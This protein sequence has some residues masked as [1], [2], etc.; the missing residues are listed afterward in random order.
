VIE[1]TVTQ[2]EGTPINATEPAPG[3]QSTGATFAPGVLQT[4]ANDEYPNVPYWGEA[5]VDD[6]S[7]HEFTYSSGTYEGQKVPCATLVATD[8]YGCSVTQISEA[9]PVSC[10]SCDESSDGWSVPYS[11]RSFTSS[12][13]SNEDQYWKSLDLLATAESNK[14]EMC[15]NILYCLQNPSVDTC[16]AL[17]KNWFGTVGSD[18]SDSANAANLETLRTGYTKIC[19]A[20]NYNYQ[21]SPSSYCTISFTYNG[22]QYNGLQQNQVSD[23]IAR[24]FVQQCREKGCTWAGTTAWVRAGISSPRE[25]NLCPIA[26]WVKNDVV[27]EKQESKSS[28]LVH[29]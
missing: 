7:M 16:Y 14:Q 5:C 24:G 11:D 4:G 6:E 18:L 26:F 23:D 27:G 25:I 1:L 12:G 10:G 20:N 13:C 29:E 22:V 3:S 2:S 28:T 8:G 17:V 15:A 19:S 9:C 21:C